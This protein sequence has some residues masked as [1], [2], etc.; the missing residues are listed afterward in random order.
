MLKLA[1]QKR[2][3][4]AAAASTVTPDVIMLRDGF[5]TFGRSYKAHIK[6]MMPYI[7][8]K[9]FS[10]STML[11]PN[12]SIWLLSTWWASFAALRSEI[13]FILGFVF[14]MHSLYII[15]QY[16]K[17]LGSQVVSMLYSGTEEPGFRFAF[18]MLSGNSLR[19]T[20]HTHYASVH[21]AAKLVAGLLRVSGD[22]C[23]PGGK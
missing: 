10:V 6:L 21:Q 14:Y 13:F 8:R 19:Q 15:I 22:N 11:C 20:A 5:M 23:R 1:S 7:S 16:Y 18:A 4:T 9:H 2:C 12:L 17:W 3:Q